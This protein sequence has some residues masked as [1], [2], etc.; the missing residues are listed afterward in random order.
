MAVTAPYQAASA[1]VL[2]AAADQLQVEESNMALQEK[3]WQY[4]DEL[5]ILVTDGEEDWYLSPTQIMWN[6]ELR[7]EEA[8]NDAAGTS[9]RKAE[10]KNEAAA[11]QATLVQRCGQVCTCPGFH[12]WN[13]TNFGCSVGGPHGCVDCDREAAAYEAAS[14]AVAATPAAEAETWVRFT[15]GGLGRVPWVDRDEL[16]DPSEREEWRE[17][18]V[19]ASAV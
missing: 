10:R 12:T 16:T 17:L 19:A 11:T 4:L 13:C 5:H 18:P 9:M 8:E 1:H 2:A 14:A 15:S 6:R 3:K 7:K